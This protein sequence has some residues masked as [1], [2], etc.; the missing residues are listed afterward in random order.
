MNRRWVF[1]SGTGLLLAGLLTLLFLFQAGTRLPERGEE[2]LNRYLAMQPGT[3]E[4][5]QITLASQPKR[6]DPQMG[7][8][9]SFRQPSSISD[10]PGL[11]RSEVIRPPTDDAG[12]PFPA[13]TIWCAQLVDRAGESPPATLILVTLHEQ[14][15][16][17]QWGLFEV[18]QR[19]A[20]AVGCWDGR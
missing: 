12:L 10:S 11:Y 1:V 8:A 7:R 9:L 17:E 14:L 15:Y 20:G 5:T 6:F 4:I 13:Q 3:I 18:N 19:V 16:T 2:E